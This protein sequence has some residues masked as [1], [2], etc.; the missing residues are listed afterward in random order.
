M[1]HRTIFIGER[2]RRARVD[3]S[4]TVSEAASALHVRQNYIQALEANDWARLPPGVYTRALIGSYA[5]WLGLDATDIL[6]LYSR[7]GPPEGE[8]VR[9][10][11]SAIR[12]PPLISV[13]AIAMVGGVVA[14]LALVAY[15]QGQYS[16]LARSLELESTVQ[17]P[18]LAT[19]AGRSIPGLLTPFPSAIPTPPETPVPSPTPVVGV[20]VEVR[21]TDRSW[22]QVWQDGS[23]VLAETLPGGGQRSFSAAREVRLRV[24]NAGGVEVTVNGAPQ[25]PLGARGQVV[26]AVWSRG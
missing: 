13:G 12:K 16:S 11:V 10:A 9:P 14:F 2:L 6:A 21:T 22:V 18:A 7:V 3:R 1:D 26:E 24:G 17:P 20:L 8:S 19:P 4:R 5:R 15:L 23:Q 25:G